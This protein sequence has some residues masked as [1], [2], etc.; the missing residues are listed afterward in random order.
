MDPPSVTQK[1]A[2]LVK[3][4]RAKHPATPIVL[5]EDRRYTNSWITPE[6]DQFHTDN[7]AALKAA[8]DTLRKEGV[9]NLFYISGD[10]LLGDD[11]DGATDG[12]HPNDL[13]FTRQANAMQPVIAKALKIGGK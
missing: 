6:K 3:Q 2:P 11:G 4:L 9:K 8:Y 1:C 13:G 10:N 5:V 12:S 7:H